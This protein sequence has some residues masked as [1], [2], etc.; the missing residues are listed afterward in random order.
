MRA[1]IDTC[2]I[3]DA[4]QS[5]EPFCK[6]AQSIFLLCANRRFDGFLT[7]KAVTDIYYLTHRQMHSDKETR[8]VLTKLCALFGIADTTALDIRRA[9]S[10]DVSDFEDAVMIETAVRSGADCIVTRNIRDYGKSPIPVYTPEEFVKRF[11]SAEDD[12]E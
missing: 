4:L 3:V 12:E 5:R 8:E 1:V 9:I 10:A 2:I 7:A 6:D 11:V